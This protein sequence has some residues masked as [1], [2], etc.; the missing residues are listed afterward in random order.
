V[1]IVEPFASPNAITYEGRDFTED[2]AR[3]LTAEIKAWAGTLWV[4]LRA[5]HDGKAHQAL[6]YA[7]WTDY[8]A[9]EFDIA[10]SQGYRLLRH[11]RDV[12]ALADAAGLPDVSPIGD[13]PEHHT[14]AIDTQAAAADI[15]AAVDAEPDAD[16]D[17][18]VEIVDEVIEK[19]RTTQYVD[20]NG[21]KIEGPSSNAPA[22]PPGPVERQDDDAATDDGGSATS[23]DGAAPEG[24]E[25]GGSGLDPSE[26][27]PPAQD[28]PELRAA[29]LA[30][31]ASK[32]AHDVRSKLLPLAPAD[33]AA[34]CPA[35]EWSAYQSLAVDLR[36]WCDEVDAA[37][38]PNLRS[39]Q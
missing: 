24:V 19:H 38:T 14:R 2:E 26:T 36:R 5:A 37:F 10:K 30:E 6:G 34:V 25:A 9:G 23:D 12:E 20:G 16:E 8:L 28:S 32:A 11:S 4:R 1:S 13:I 17:R 39:V 31:R 33:I 35:D 21:E 18:R 3:R 15:A 7:T 29:K 27:Q 22:S